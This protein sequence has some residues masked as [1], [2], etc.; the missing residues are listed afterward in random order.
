MSVSGAATVQ[1]NVSVH[2]EY[3]KAPSIDLRSGAVLRLTDSSTENRHIRTD[4]LLLASDLTGMPTAGLDLGN[5]FLIHDIIGDSSAIEAVVRQWL[6]AGRNNG[7]WNGP[8]ISTRAAAAI[9]NS[10]LG[11][12]LS[13]D[14]GSPTT[15]QSEQLNGSALLVLFTLSGDANLDR[16]VDLADF[17]RLVNGFNLEGNWARGDFDYSG[18]VDIADFAQLV[19]SYNLSLPAMPPP[20][21]LGRIVPEPTVGG[22][23]LVGAAG[24][25]RRRSR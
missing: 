14:I 20:A 17:S 9:P 8:G 5:G 4:S 16:T 21:T 23:M 18:T 22:L 1:P 19:A 24:L 11:Y 10:A 15:F 7:A 2:A 25:L 13:A 12:A 3:F 6:V